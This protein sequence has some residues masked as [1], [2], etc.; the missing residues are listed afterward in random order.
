MEDLRTSLAVA[1]RQLPPGAEAAAAMLAWGLVAGPQMAAHATAV[2]LD[3]GVLRLRV[4]DA[5]WRREIL[6][7]RP[8]LLRQLA[9]VLG[10]GKVLGLSCW[11]SAEEPPVFARRQAPGEECR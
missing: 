9:V 6:A 2:A 4:A 5:A 3:N 8:E 11:P 7:L 1:L 10:P